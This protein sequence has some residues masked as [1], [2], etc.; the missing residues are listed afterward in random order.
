MKRKWFS[1]FLTIGLLVT[2]T[3]GCTQSGENS[4]ALSDDSSDAPV[5]TTTTTTNTDVAEGTTTL[6]EST[7][8][9]VVTGN[10]PQKTEPS[11]TKKPITSGTTN[12]T[13]KTK[14]PSTTNQ[15]TTSRT[16]RITQAPSDSTEYIGPD[17]LNLKALADRAL[18]NVGNSDRLLR[19]FERARSGEDIV[20]G[21]IGGSITYGAGATDMSKS[22]VQK[23][24][25]WFQDTFRD[26][27]VTVVNAGICATTSFYGVHRA[28]RDLLQ[29]E[30]DFVI[31]EFAVNDSDIRIMENTYEM[32]VRNI[33]E[34]PTQ[35]A[36][37]LLCSMSEGG[38][39]VQE[40]HEK[41]AEHYQ[42]PLVSYKN[43]LW[44]EVASGRIKF[45][46]ITADTVHPNDAGHNAMAYFVTDALSRIYKQKL[47]LDKRAYVVPSA[48]CYET[49]YD[50]KP[51]MFKNARMVNTDEIKAKS[52]GDVRI[53]DIGY[54]EKA[55]EISKNASIDIDISGYS[56]VAFR[57]LYKNR[58]DMGSALIQ[59]NNGTAVLHNGSVDMLL[60]GWFPAAGA[61]TSLNELIVTGLDTAAKNTMTVIHAGI[62][63]PDHPGV[64]GEH[65]YIIDLMVSE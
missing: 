56:A 15:T 36:V 53:V 3:V 18:V 19:V 59:V 61:E 65:F 29:Y 58:E 28:Q 60:D 64:T 54:G 2:G 10:Q 25:K 22:Y 45:S 17:M 52:K 5:T 35:P 62:L 41:V 20:I 21:M 51:V 27:N 24:S 42:L 30:P 9:T 44:P 37:M 7:G 26:S 49:V 55:Y 8:T 16:T 39:N 6:T 13:P 4:S 50:E 34:S 11:V 48:T 23:V 57:Y 40:W 63:S 1:L 12:T 32:L 43:A 38:N 31:V 14:K 47:D 46:D 33:L